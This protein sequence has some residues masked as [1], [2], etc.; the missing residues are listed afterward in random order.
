[1][2]ASTYFDPQQNLT[3]EH[4][5]SRRLSNPVKQFVGMYV[6]VRSK[7][8][9]GTNRSIFDEHVPFCNSNLIIK[10]QRV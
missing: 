7:L 1:M 10:Q 6:I 2:F 8:N 9:R 5:L 3:V 4:S